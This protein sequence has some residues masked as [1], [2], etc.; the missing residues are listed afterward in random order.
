[1]SKNWKCSN[2]Q[3]VASKQ[4][5]ALSYQEDSMN[6]PVI[7]G[8]AR[9]ERATSMLRLARR[10]GIPITQNQKLTDSLSHVQVDHEIPSSTYEEV[11]RLF[12]EV[13]RRA[14]DHS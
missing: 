11:A 6:T 5:I 4:A 10:Y 8:S 13:S 12:C 7:S 14:T 2:N 1:M 9:G 3:G